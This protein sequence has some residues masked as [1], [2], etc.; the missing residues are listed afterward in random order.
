MARFV[1]EAIKTKV[2]MHFKR[3]F[4]VIVCSIRNFTPNVDATVKIDGRTVHSMPTLGAVRNE[5]Q[6]DS[7]SD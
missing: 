5:L 7:I 1:I 4:L 6:N 3:Y 2:G